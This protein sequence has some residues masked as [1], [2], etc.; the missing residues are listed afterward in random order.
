MI[1][2][3]GAGARGR[4][5]VTQRLSCV[6]SRGPVERGHNAVVETR[7]PGVAVVLLD[8]IK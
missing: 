3:D 5:R 2:R 4:A 7:G 1:L 8:I 6:L